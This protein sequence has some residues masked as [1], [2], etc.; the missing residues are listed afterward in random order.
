[1]KTIFFRES[2]RYNATYRQHAL[3]CLGDFVELQKRIDLSQ[4]VYSIVEPVITQALDTSEDMDVDS[5]SNGLSSKLLYFI[6]F[7]HDLRMLLNSVQERCECG[8]L[9]GCAAK[10]NQWSATKHTRYVK[11]TWRGTE[12]KS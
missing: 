5:L 10:V 7:Q 11:Q 6:Y 9:A 8:K 3:A 1:M 4:E 2:K 12:S